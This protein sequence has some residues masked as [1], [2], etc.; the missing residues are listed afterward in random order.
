MQLGMALPIILGNVMLFISVPILAER[1]ERHSTFAG[2]ELAIM[3]KLTF[4]QVPALPHLTLPTPLPYHTLPYLLPGAQHD[5]RRLLLPR[6][7]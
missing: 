1:Y 5:G 2:M 7:P 3:L 6:R 4:F